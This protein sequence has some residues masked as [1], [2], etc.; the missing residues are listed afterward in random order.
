MPDFILNKLVRDNIP[1]LM[2]SAGQTPIFH[3]LQGHALQKAMLTKIKEEVG[4]AI[5]A[6]DNDDKF[7]NE[8]ADIQELIDSL[9]AERGI[10]RTALIALQKNTHNKK[11][12]FKEGYFL[13]KVSVDEASEWAQ[14]YR[15]EPDRFGESDVA[16]IDTDDVPE[17]QLGVYEHYKGKHYEI[18][19]LGRHSETQAWFVVYKPLYEHD[20]Q[21]DIWIRPYEMFTET[22][23]VE[24]KETPRFKKL[25]SDD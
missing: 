8:L 17:L 13:E 1:S 24:G 20:G 23:V 4:E 19:G 22:V 9:L 25:A 5:G 15:N 14:Y 7:A 21:P 10:K 11:G 16:N 12:S 3:V 18:L 2:K 6:I